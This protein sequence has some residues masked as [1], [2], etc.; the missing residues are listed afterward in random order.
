MAMNT[1]FAEWYKPAS[2]NL[3]T[4]LLESRWKAIE[5]VRKSI[6]SSQTLSLGE[7]FTNSIK[8]HLIDQGFLIDAIQKEDTTFIARDSENELAVLSGVILRTIIDEDS[9]FATLAA[10]AI[11]TGSFGPREGLLT[12]SGHLKVARAY[13]ANIGAKMQLIPPQPKWKKLPLTPEKLAELLTPQMFQANQTTTMRDPLISTISGLIEAL[14]DFQSQIVSYSTAVAK[15]VQ[16]HEEESQ[17]LWWLQTKQSRDLKKPF[18]ELEKNAAV[19]LLAKEL[20]D[21]TAVDSVSISALGALVRALSEANL[22]PLTDELNI[23]DC[24]NS[25]PRQWKESISK[26]TASTPQLLCPVSFAFYKSLDTD[27]VETWYPVYKKACDLDLQKRYPAIIL[28]QQFY[29]ECLLIRI[30]K[31]TKA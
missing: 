5:I 21:M 20:A 10:L 31:Q 18:S 8:S 15:I 14:R 26:S 2:V 3:R 17:I 7:L 23:A 16:I 22:N 27:E 25:T 28:A 29:Y 24:V 6:T 1:N 11:V 19:A 30:S 4:E 13:L 9:E 12:F